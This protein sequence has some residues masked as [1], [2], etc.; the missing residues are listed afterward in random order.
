MFRSKRRS[1]FKKGRNVFQIRRGELFFC[2]GVSKF[3]REVFRL[4]LSKKKNQGLKIAFTS[5]TNM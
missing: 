1:V 2:R 3:R 4:F 5:F